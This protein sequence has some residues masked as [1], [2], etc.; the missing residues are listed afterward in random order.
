M[1]SMPPAGWRDD[2][3]AGRLLRDSLTRIAAKL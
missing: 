2:T 3:H 1:T